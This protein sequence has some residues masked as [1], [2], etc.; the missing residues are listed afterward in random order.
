VTRAQVDLE[1]ERRRLDLALTE[2]HRQHD[3]VTRVYA[4]A[5]RGVATARAGYRNARTA[6]D[7]G[8]LPL[9]TLVEATKALV[10]ATENLTAAA[11][12][13][14]L[15]ELQLR[16]A[17]GL[18]LLTAEQLAPIMQHVDFPREPGAP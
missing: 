5:E 3:D 8:V 18:P 13:R 17:A 9:T 7:Q 11:Y 1:G 6:Y 16:Q 2:A 14:A 4:V 15:A 12:G 10:E